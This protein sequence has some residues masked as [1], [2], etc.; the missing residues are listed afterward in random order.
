[1]SVAQI[2]RW[3]N[4]RSDRLSIGQRLIVR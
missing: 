4:L 2:K 3:N 1:V